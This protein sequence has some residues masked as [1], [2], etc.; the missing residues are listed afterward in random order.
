MVRLPEH[1]S[2]GQVLPVWFSAGRGPAPASGLP[3][4][5][6]WL[7]RESAGAPP[8]WHKPAAGR[9]RSERR[10]RTCARPR[11]ARAASQKP[12][13]AAAAAGAGGGRRQRVCDAQRC[14][15]GRRGLG[16]PHVPQDGA[17]PWGRGAGAALLHTLCLSR[18]SVPSC[19][20]RLAGSSRWK[21]IQ[22]PETLAVCSHAPGS[23]LCHREVFSGKENWMFILPARDV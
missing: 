13:L 20:V 23:Q 14:V 22:A 6:F 8:P 5:L 7:G 2:G 10:A 17:R 21:C 4:G 18:E 19:R 15:A 12:D 3:A 16:Q 1:V 9:R 11:R